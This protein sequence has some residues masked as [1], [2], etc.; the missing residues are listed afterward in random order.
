MAARFGHLAAVPIATDPMSKLRTTII[1]N[2]R[3]TGERYYPAPRGQPPQPGGQDLVTDEQPHD[4]KDDVEDDRHDDLGIRATA[5]LTAATAKAPAG[6]TTEPVDRAGQGQ[7]PP[8]VVGS[9]RVNVSPR[10]VMPQ[11][12]PR[13]GM[14]KQP[15]QD[16][17]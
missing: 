16:R 2:A 7:S 12:A 1:A 3:E 4:D 17:N 9:V 14:R 11:E 8:A 10:T 5:R 6:I 13:T 15:T